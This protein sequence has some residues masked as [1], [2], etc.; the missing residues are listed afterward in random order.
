[1][2]GVS[3]WKESSVLEQPY[4]RCPFRVCHLSPCYVLGIFLIH[5]A[6]EEASRQRREPNAT[7]LWHMHK[8]NFLPKVKIHSVMT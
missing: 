5:I 8:V 4:Y 6:P 1:M 2:S 7:R 3:Y